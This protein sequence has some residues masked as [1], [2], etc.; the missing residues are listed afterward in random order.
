MAVSSRFYEWM[1]PGWTRLLNREV[2]PRCW[3]WPAPVE[4][5]LSDDDIQR[6]HAQCS[7]T[8]NRLL[9][10]LLGF[11]FFCLL[12]LGGSDTALLG[13]NEQVA[14]PVV[15][16]SLSIVAFLLVG[17]LVLIAS[18][19]I[20]TFLQSSYGD[21]IRSMPTNSYRLSLTCATPYRG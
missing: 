7:E 14:V 20:C 1:R 19:C 9:F 17:P 18:A 8:A 12:T 5:R 13:A 21:M 15:N 4:V 11:C 3:W 2:P 16:I 6:Q 10:T